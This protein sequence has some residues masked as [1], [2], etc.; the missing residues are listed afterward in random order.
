[1]TDR[2]DNQLNKDLKRRFQPAMPLFRSHS[3][4][5]LEKNEWEEDSKEDKEVQTDNSKTESDSEDLVFIKR[6]PRRLEECLEIYESQ[7]GA[8]GLTDEEVILLVKNKAIAS[9]QIEKAVDNPERGVGIRR[10]MIGSSGNLSQ[11]L[12]DLPYKNYDYS[13][14]SVSTS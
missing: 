10:K 6:P 2:T 3:S 4:F 8:D 12:V 13:K 7:L 5:F 11:A 9:Y 14:V 1:M